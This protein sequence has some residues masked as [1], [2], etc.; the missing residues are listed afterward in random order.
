MTAITAESGRH[1]RF[2]V[3]PA[4]ALARGRRLTLIRRIGLAVL[5]LQAAEFLVWSTVLYQRFALTFDFATYQQAWFEIAHGTSTAPATRCG[6]TS[7][8]KRAP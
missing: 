6:R 5:G 3:R 8:W 1:R 7:R 2:R 4:V